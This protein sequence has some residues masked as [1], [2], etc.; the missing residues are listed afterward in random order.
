MDRDNFR[1]T[2]RVISGSTWG[3]EEEHPR[4]LFGTNRQ[5]SYRR[6]VRDASGGLLEIRLVTIPGKVLEMEARAKRVGPPRNPAI[7]H[8]GARFGLDTG[9]AGGGGYDAVGDE[10]GRLSR[11]GMNR[12]RAG[13]TWVSQG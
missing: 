6:E 12:I 4:G 13:V 8:P 10:A 11:I 9:D 5:L 2:W 7:S 1:L 3:M